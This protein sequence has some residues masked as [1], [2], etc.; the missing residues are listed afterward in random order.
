MDEAKAA[1]DSVA[2][3]SETVTQSVLRAELTSLENRLIKGGITI[4]IALAGVTVAA[5]G[6]IVKFIVG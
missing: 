2:Q 1:A 6:M 4:A 3:V 5:I